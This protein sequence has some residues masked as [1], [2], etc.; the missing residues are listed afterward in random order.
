ML[1]KNSCLWMIGVQM[2]GERLENVNWLAYD[3][4]TREMLYYGTS[5]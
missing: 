3:P 4:D 2:N 1:A 5:Y